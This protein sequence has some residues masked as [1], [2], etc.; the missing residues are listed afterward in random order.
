[1]LKTN[2]HTHT[3]YCDGKGSVEEITETAIEKG[4]DFLGF[5]S[6]SAWPFASDWH[7]APREI[8]KYISDVKKTAEKYRDKIKILCGFEADYIPKITKPSLKNDYSSFNPDFLIGS[9]HYLV[10]EN[11]NF[12]VDDKTE[13]VKA[14]IDI[15]FNGDGKKCVQEYFKAQREM[16]SAGDFTIWGHPDLVR[17]RNGILRFF[18]EKSDWYINEL[19]ETA[20]IAAK[21]GA[22]AEINTGAIS[23]GAM[24]DVYPSSDFLSILHEHGVPITLSSDSHQKEHLDFAFER[25]LD[26]GIRAGYTEIAY[27]DE[28]RKIR[29]Q[30]IEI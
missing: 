27:I 12:T 8:K 30:K 1:M 24:D 23:R 26:A 14:G 15:C 9:V 19:R 3:E 6:H 5:S 10:T 11:G 2:Y 7:I 20:K 17:K 4:F 18:D 25:A 16:L 29:F 28:E 21:N 13:N 22:I